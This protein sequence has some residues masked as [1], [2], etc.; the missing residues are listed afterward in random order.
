MSNST[1]ITPIL[2]SDT[3]EISLLLRMRLA[4]TMIIIYDHCDFHLG[5]YVERRNTGAPLK[6]HVAE[7][8]VVRKSSLFDTI[9]LSNYGYFTTHLTN[10]L[11]VYEVSQSKHTVLTYTRSLSTGFRFFKWELWAG[12]VGGLLAEG[13]T[14]FAEAL[15]HGN[16]TDQFPSNSSFATLRSIFDKEENSSFNGDVLSCLFDFLCNYLGHYYT[17]LA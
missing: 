13:L 12:L 6:D 7:Q 2:I 15:K 3:K 1:S 14:H 5:K 9:S 16:L 4:S 8:V 10:E 17:H 11:F